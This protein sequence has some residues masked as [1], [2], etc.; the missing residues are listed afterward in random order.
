MYMRWRLI[1]A[2]S[3]SVNLLLFAGWMAS[4]SRAASAAKSLAALSASTNVA[5]TRSPNVVVRRQFFSW[6]DLESADYPTYIANLRDIGCPEQTIRDIIIADVNALF[7]KR[8]ATETL[9]PEQQW[10]RTTPDPE[11]ER[12]AAEKTAAIEKERR[13]LLA[14]LLGPSWESGDL[15]NLPRPT[16]P[17]VVLDGPVLGLLNAD[18]KQTVQD[19][20]QKSEQRLNEYLDKIRAGG[21]Q[22]DP[23]ELGRLRR[24][25]REELA[26]VLTP[27]QLEEFLLRYS[28]TADELR[29][30]F[31]ELQHFNPTPDEFRSVFRAVDTFDYQLSMLPE[32]S[33]DP[34]IAQQRRS[35]MT[36]R[37]NALHVA[38]GNRRYEEYRMLNDPVYRDAVTQAQEA[39]TPE[40]ARTIYQV[41][42]AALAEQASITNN[43]SL[44]PEQ[45]S[46][47]LKQLEVDQMKA[48]ALAAGQELPP[49]Q[50]PL[51][52]SAAPVRRTYTIQPGDSLAVVAMIYG[53][54]ASAIR[55]A[56]PNLD[57]NRLQPGTTLTIPRTTT[58]PPPPIPLPPR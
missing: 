31:G 55:N 20:S 18:T 2:I 51:P 34:R 52:Q 37:E 3:L 4:R 17:G 10:W 9:T 28:M 15:A 22:P 47:E 38:L 54:P 53:V 12:V 45:R 8:L 46:I 35:L 25:T 33:N 5:P 26:R 42:L 49:E 43:P 13:T 19:I 21:G 36:Q 1:T 23:A 48:N 50:P 39:G 27:S 14:S 41:N 16:R 30:T 40:A 32:D 29:A 7:A 6:R 58:T 44:T 56:N 24:Q 57:L 11:V